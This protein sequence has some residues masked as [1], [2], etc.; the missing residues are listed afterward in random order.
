MKNA[1]FFLVLTMNL[2]LSFQ[3]MF[4]VD[5]RSKDDMDREKNVVR[6]ESSIYNICR[7]RGVACSVERK[8]LRKTTA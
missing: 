2:V 4:T 7:K 1:E 8:V 5:I 6:I 3:V